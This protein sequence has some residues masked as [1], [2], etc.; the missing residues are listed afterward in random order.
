[1]RNVD[2]KPLSFGIVE[3]SFMSTFSCSL[4]RFVE[5]NIKIQAIFKMHDSIKTFKKAICHSIKN[6]KKL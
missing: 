6:P 5:I 2:I 3:L 1:M 4:M